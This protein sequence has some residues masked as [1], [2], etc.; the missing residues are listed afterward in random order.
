MNIFYYITFFLLL[1]PSEF[2]LN[3]HSELSKHCLAPN[4]IFYKNIYELKNNNFFVN[5]ESFVFG[6][7]SYKELEEM[8][9]FIAAYPNQLSLVG[10][11]ETEIAKKMISIRSRLYLEIQKGNIL[12]NLEKVRDTA[13]NF[14]KNSEQN[15]KCRLSV[16]YELSLLGISPFLE[17]VTIPD[18]L[19]FKEEL[20]KT[21]KVNVENYPL[22]GDW[23][24]LPNYEEEIARL[25]LMQ[26]NF[27]LSVGMLYN[28]VRFS[29]EEF[30]DD[31]L[32]LEISSNDIKDSQILDIGSN[33]GGLGEFLFNNYSI[34]SYTGIDW[35]LDAI[36]RATLTSKKLNFHAMNN[37]TLAFKDNS[38]DLIILNN[39]I[40][41]CYYKEMQRVLRKQGKI[42]VTGKHQKE[43]ALPNG[44]YQFSNDGKKLLMIKSM[45]ADDIINLF[46]FWKNNKVG[47]TFSYNN[48]HE[49]LIEL[50][51]LAATFQ[52]A[53][54]RCSK[55]EIEK[56]INETIF[57]YYEYDPIIYELTENILEA[58]KNNEDLR[59]LATKN[60][61]SDS[62]RKIIL[63][64]ISITPEKINTIFQNFERA[65]FFIELETISLRIK[66]YKNESKLK[67]AA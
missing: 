65:E 6:D 44:I 5:K 34:K 66:E 28:E 53:G 45:L 4:S 67:K 35:D 51:T 25:R 26:V 21:I 24:A 37:K 43:G 59:I 61:I 9:T 38:F 50:L 36:E 2:F 42:L 52:K 27:Q 55:I 30:E 18:Y 11:I 14:L 32:S 29:K 60:N 47:N 63:D 48:Y 31:L 15:L 49:S 64:L 12:K 54:M 7:I 57:R 22:K 8:F 13:L 19:K 41:P 56:I 39:F 3:K 40:G 20:Y 58:I 23:T 33:E 62:H 16:E 1:T 17:I 10:K 46:D